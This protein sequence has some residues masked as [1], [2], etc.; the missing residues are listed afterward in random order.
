MFQ[1]ICLKS[2]ESIDQDSYI[3]RHIDTMLFYGEVI[4]L[5]Q[6]DQLSL[7]LRY[8]GE[9][10]LDQLIKNGRLKIFIRQNRVGSMMVPNGDQENYNVQLVSK[11]D[12]TA[13]GVLYK[14]YHEIFNNSTTSL[15]FADK[16]SGVIRPFSYQPGIIDQ[17]RND[18]KDVDLLRKTLPIYLNSLV[19]NYY[20]PK[21]LNVEIVEEASYG[22][23][24]TYALK[25]NIDLRE[26]NTSYNLINPGNKIPMGYSGFFLSLAEAKG[27]I[28]I[29]SQFLSELVTRDLYSKFIEIELSDIVNRRLK[30]EENLNLFEEYILRDCHS[31]G[32]AF[33]EGLISRKELF[34]ILVKGDKFRGWLDKVPEDKNLIGEYYREVTKGSITDKLP[35]KTLRFIIIN[36][37]GITIELYNP[38]VLGVAVATG[39]HAIDDFYLEKL[40]KGW[41][42]NHFIDDTLIPKIKK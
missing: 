33:T 25:S 21:E 10:L 9:D 24:G 11:K 5:V 40:I 30:S 6:N 20:V 39:L 36:G 18:F 35:L 42:P 13:E 15:R 12:E 38:G 23:F 32:H 3:A 22:P 1:R 29:A 16:F 17:I 14:S 7:L 2:E 26:V 37:I 28:Y 34:T 27:D 31:L 19:P 8:F 4:T 41:R